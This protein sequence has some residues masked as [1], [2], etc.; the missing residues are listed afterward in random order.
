MQT[1]IDF[2][3]NNY[4]WFL[5]ISLILIFALIGYFVDVNEKKNLTKSE[6]NTSE[7]SQNLQQTV[8]TLEIGEKK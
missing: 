3:V 4:F 8:D 6:N 5:I 1:F 7:P 2:L